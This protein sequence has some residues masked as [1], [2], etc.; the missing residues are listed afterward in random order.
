MRQM[1]METR[2]SDVAPKGT[3]HEIWCVCRLTKDHG[4]NRLLFRRYLDLSK[5]LGDDRQDW[6]AFKLTQHLH[7][8]LIAAND[9]QYLIP[10]ESK[11]EYPW[12]A[13]EDDFAGFWEVEINAKLKGLMALMG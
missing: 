7:L 4:G 9:F 10:C 11:R 1:Q 3:T 8:K 2:V 13:D 6:V 5:I 12:C